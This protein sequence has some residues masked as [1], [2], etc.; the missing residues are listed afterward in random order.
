MKTPAARRVRDL[1]YDTLVTE[2]RAP[3]VAEIARITETTTTE[4][5]T[6][7]D[8]LAEDHALVLS[9]D[10]DAIRM[11]HPFSAAPMAF[12]VT[13]LDGHDD[14]RWWGG[15]AWDSFGISS[16]LHLDVRIDTACPHCAT[17]LTYEAGPDTAPPGELA[18]RFPRPA[19]HWWDDV[20]GTC[21]MIRTFC[22]RDH[23]DRW[24][25]DHAP[26]TGYIA[27]ATAVWQLARPWYGDRVDPQFTPHTR[28]HN[29]QLLDQ[30]GLTG[31]FW[32]LP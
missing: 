4:T 2:G 19:A 31:P 15:C 9:P 29:Q 5:S 1:V 22:T 26:G 30:V 25:T 21:T 32:A 23:A 6:L 7:L 27:Q 20:V 24:T 14:R 17:H 13:P 12:V 18:V 10:G 3:S 8:E 11:A 28:E 16:A